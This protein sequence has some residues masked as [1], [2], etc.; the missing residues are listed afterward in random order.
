MEQILGLGYGNI[1]VD[2]VVDQRNA[3]LSSPSGYRMVPWL[4]WG[5]WESVKDS[6]FSDSPHKVAFALHRIST[7]RSRGCLPV[8]IDVTASIIEIQQK[9]PVYRKDLSGDAAHSEQMLAMLY[10][11][12]ILRLVN[13]VIEKTRKKNDASIGEAA[14]AIG[15]PRTLIDI[16][17]EGSHR[18]LPALPLVRDSAVKAIEWLKWYYWQPQTMQIPS[19]RDGACIRKEIKSKLLE[20][21]SWSKVKQIPDTRTSP[22]PGKKGGR[23]HKQSCGSYKIFSMVVAGKLHSSKFC[24]SKKTVSR[25]LKSL[26]QLNS[27]FPS[28]ILSVLLELLLKALDSTNLLE[29]RNEIKVGEKN[30]LDVW[31]LMVTRFSKKEPELLLTLTRSVLNLIESEESM[32]S[33]MGMVPPSTEQEMQPSRT[34]GLGSVFLWLI[35]QLQGLKET[36]FSKDAKAETKINSTG[37]SMSNAIL[38]GILRKCL[39]ASSCGNK[40]LMDGAKLLAELTGKS[41]LIEKLNRLSSHYLSAAAPVP[42]ETASGSPNHEEYLRQ[43]TEKLKEV[44]QHRRNQGQLLSPTAGEKTDS[45]RWV[46]AK[47]WNPCPIGMLPGDLGTSGRLPVLD[48]EDTGK[49]SAVVQERDQTP[50]LKKDNNST[51]QSGA[52]FQSWDDRS[53]KKRE[54]SCLPQKSGA[55]KMRHSSEVEDEATPAVHSLDGC[56]LIDGAWKKVAKEELLGMMSAVKILL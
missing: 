11:M 21:A 55:K 38:M 4:N 5:E 41:S 42:E 19:Q 26:V 46:V 39:L 44:L 18:D 22:S 30:L 32:D 50:E 10:C 23:Y 53:L 15:I 12:A 47:G 8:V 52:N 14:G 27:S 45:D 20:L 35:G 51:K 48:S 25:I 56:L 13:C 37:M 3:T 43:A 2:D 54:A 6:L 40:Q 17:H 33:R 24:G 16:R 31:K 36:L 34:E 49:K 9:D 1:P 29:L 28:E 7:W